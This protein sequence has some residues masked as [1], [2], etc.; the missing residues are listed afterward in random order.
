[1]IERTSVSIVVLMSGEQF[2][3][4]P[5][6]VVARPAD[7]GGFFLK[8]STASLCVCVCGVDLVELCDAKFVVRTRSRKIAFAFSSE[9]RSLR[10]N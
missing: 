7:L 6:F 5:R 4:C 8:R 9:A 1:M 3:S 2:L 10:T